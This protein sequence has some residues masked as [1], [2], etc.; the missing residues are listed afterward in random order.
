MGGTEPDTSLDEFYD[1]L[2]DMV[3]SQAGRIINNDLYTKSLLSSLPV[4]LISTDKNGLVQVATVFTISRDRGKY[5]AGPRP[6]GF[7]LSRFRRPDSGRRPAEG[8]QYP[9]P[10]VL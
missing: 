7:C 8:G 2:Q 4:A 3:I 5:Q 6:T 1:N 9:C 10:A